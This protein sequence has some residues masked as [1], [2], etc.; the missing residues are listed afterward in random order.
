MNVTRQMQPGFNN[1][2]GVQIPNMA[3]NYYNTP[4]ATSGGPTGGTSIL[5][6]KQE[7]GQGQGQHPPQYHHPGYNQH[8]QHM[9]PNYPQDMDEVSRGGDSEGDS[10]SQYSTGKSNLKNIVNDI[11]DAI[12]EEQKIKSKNKKSEDDTEEEDEDDE[13]DGD[14]VK[15]KNNGDD[16]DKLKLFKLLKDPLLLWIIY[17]MLSQEFIKNI[18]GNYV[19]SIN[20]GDDGSVGVIG[21][22]VYGI[23]LVVAYLVLRY[24]FI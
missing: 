1:S 20:P 14:E 16:Q 2:S 7:Q 19:P 23:V 5:A 12:D 24:I 3:N 9:Q 13:D 8:S 21:V 22:A 18:I 17:M 10:Q 11:N 4:P 15:V 6:L